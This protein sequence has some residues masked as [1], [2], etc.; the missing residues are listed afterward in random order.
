MG[1]KFWDCRYQ[2]AMTRHQAPGGDH[3]RR[4]GQLV[5]PSETD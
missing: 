1:D 4:N 3:Q 5:M 2:E